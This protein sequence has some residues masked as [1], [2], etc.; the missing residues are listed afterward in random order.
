MVL[1]EIGGFNDQRDCLTMGDD[2]RGQKLKSV[3]MH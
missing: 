2:Q 1:M 3:D